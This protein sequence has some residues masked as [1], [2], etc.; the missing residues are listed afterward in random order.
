LHSSQPVTRR[1][2]AQ[3]INVRKIFEA[4]IVT[5]FQSILPDKPSQIP[6]I[7]NVSNSVFSE[8]STSSGIREDALK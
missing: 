4:R 1:I 8:V 6:F 7:P 5:P 2:P 3:K